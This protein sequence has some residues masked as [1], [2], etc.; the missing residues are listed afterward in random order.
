M[1]RTNTSAKI[2][3]MDWSSAYGL[4]QSGPTTVLYSTGRTP[5]RENLFKWVGPIGTWSLT[6]YARADSNLSIAGLADARNA[7]TICVVED[8]AR[9]GFL[10]K[11]NFTNIMTVKRDEECAKKLAWNEVSLWMASSTSFRVVTAKAGVKTTDFRP[12]LAAGV[13]EIYVAFSPDT[14]DY[15]VSAWQES[16]NEMKRDGTF[17][18]IAGEYDTLPMPGS[19]RDAHGCIP[20]AGYSWCEGKNKCLRIWEEPCTAQDRAEKAKTYCGLEDVAMVSVC[21]EYIRVTGSAAGY[22][23]TF[24]PDEG[25]EI[26]CAI[27]TP[28]M[29]AGNCRLLLFGSNCVE[30]VVCDNTK[31]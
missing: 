6:L 26:R 24:Y 19:D 14:P 4:A 2:E 25:K 21:G 18:S 23:S 9:H 16:L 28:D 22:G 27:M 1:R 12:V 30:Q 20:S 3:M 17:N 11:N 29:M 5:E 15:I 13:N 8:D 7:K 10:L 31:K